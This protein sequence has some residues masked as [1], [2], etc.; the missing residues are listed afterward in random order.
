MN[1]SILQIVNLVEGGIKSKN[2]KFE[3]VTLF[4]TS[5]DIKFGVKYRSKRS[6]KEG[7][8]H[9]L[10]NFIKNQKIVFLCFF[11]HSKY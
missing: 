1:Y 5:C 2:R 10:F 9:V 6:H 11:V 4:V 8:S 7:L 3:K